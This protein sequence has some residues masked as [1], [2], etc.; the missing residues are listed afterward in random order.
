MLSPGIKVFEADRMIDVF[1]DPRHIMV[2]DE[3]GRSVA[4]PRAMAA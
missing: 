4:A 1:I 3:A 2:F